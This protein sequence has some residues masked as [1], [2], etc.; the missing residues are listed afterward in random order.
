[1]FTMLPHASAQQVRLQALAAEDIHISSFGQAG[2]EFDCIVIG[3]DM[4]HEITLNQ[5][6]S[7]KIVVFA[8]DAPLQHDI[9]VWVDV[10]DDDKLVLRDPGGYSP[11]PG[12]PL[13][14]RFAYA[15]NGYANNNTVWQNAIYDAI[16]VPAGSRYASFP[17]SRMARPKLKHANREVPLERAFLFF[18]GSLGPVAPGDNLPSGVYETSITVYVDL[19]HRYK[20][21]Q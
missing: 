6:N 19:T 17:I 20:P 1:M 3:T 11:P 21:D 5:Q 2:L 16:E 13:E 10:F 12:I 8:V 18:Y 14:I 15:N 9:S 7:H 4:R